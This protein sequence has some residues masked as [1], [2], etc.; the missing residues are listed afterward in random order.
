MTPG[1]SYAIERLEARRL[2][3]LEPLW[4]ELREDHF[5][6]A[7]ELG[8]IRGRRDSWERRRLQ[9]ECWLERPGSEIL[10]AGAGEDLYGYAMVEVA[11]GSPL[12]D[13]GQHVGVLQSLAV[14]PERRGQGIGSALIEATRAYLHRIGVPTVYLTVVPWNPGILDF[15]E[16]H[17]FQLQALRMQAYTD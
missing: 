10:V 6:S 5:I 9:Y 17:D 14:R 4:N 11:P 2:D 7:P 16:R 8:P 12:W 15:L 13:D 1:S 3:L